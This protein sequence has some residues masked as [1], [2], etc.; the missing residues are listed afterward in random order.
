MGLS[1]GQPSVPRN[2]IQSNPG[3]AGLFIR[4]EFLPLRKG[5]GRDGWMLVLTVPIAGRSPLSLAT[6][7]RWLGWGIG[8]RC[9]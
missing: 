7:E 1:R 2:A 5:L 3:A 8:R 4:K 6:E 9:Q